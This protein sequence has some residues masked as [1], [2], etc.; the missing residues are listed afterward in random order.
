MT[1]REKFCRKPDGSIVFLACKD[2]NEF[3]EQKA[4]LSAAPQVSGDW[5]LVPVEPTPE[6]YELGDQSTSAYDVYKA[7]LSAAPIPSKIDALI[8]AGQRWEN[9]QDSAA[10]TPPGVGPIAYLCT[11]PSNPDRLIKHYVNALKYADIY[12]DGTVKITPLYT[13]PPAPKAEW[14]DAGEPLNLEAAAKDAV[15]FIIE[16]E[17]DDEGCLLY[18][19]VVDN[20]RKFLGES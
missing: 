20:L 7:M 15:E 5:R 1:E 18:R 4:A 16:T 11:H 2:A 8:D 9:A 3:T 12:I 6:M 13:S 19:D 17:H 14:S 10:P